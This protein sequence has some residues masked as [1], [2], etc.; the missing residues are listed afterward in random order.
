MSIK[1]RSTVENGVLII[2]ASGRDENAQ[3]V[4][5]YGRSVIQLIV[6]SGTQ[7]V[8]CDESELEYALSTVDTFDAAKQ[9]AFEAAKEI[10]ASAPNV[11]RVAIVCNPQFWDDAKFWETVAVNRGLRVVVDTDISRAMAWL[12]EDAE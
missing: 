4:I 1:Y 10:A 11:A 9:I 8:L 3:Q 2:K 7:R 12:T 5:E 6:E